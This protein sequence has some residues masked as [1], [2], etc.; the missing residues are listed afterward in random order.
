MTS[1]RSSPLAS[2]SPS[3]VP[4][5]RRVST[6]GPATAPR[7]CRSSTARVQ[8]RQ[9]ACP[10]HEPERRRRHVFGA[11]RSDSDAASPHPPHALGP[12]AGRRCSPSRAD[13]RPRATLAACGLRLAP[14][15][16]DAGQPAKSPKVPKTLTEGSPRAVDVAGGGLFDTDAALADAKALTA[17]GVRPGGS[18][19]G[20][21]GGGLH[22][23]AA[24]GHGARARCRRVPASERQD[25][26]KR[27]RRDSRDLIGSH[28]RHR[29]ALRH[30]ATL[31]GRQRQR[32][33]MRDRAGVGPRAEGEPCAGGRDARVLWHRGV[34]ASTRLATTITSALA[35]MPQAS[36]RTSSMTS[37]R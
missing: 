2:S 5:L 18:P 27:H 30:Q 20:E 17:F 9:L 22:R 35:H 21:A 1:P 15:E 31:T 10:A 28:G 11:P 36:R 6:A 8:S 12:G 16:A 37:P 29:R 4:R 33:W 19:R 34:L 24:A 7:H 32:F 23:E 26:P 25:E 13:A 3:S 14:A